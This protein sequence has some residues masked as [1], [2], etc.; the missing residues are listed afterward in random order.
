MKRLRE[1][2]DGFESVGNNNNNRELMSRKI[3]VKLIQNE[4]DNSLSSQGEMEW[5]EG[6]VRSLNPQPCID[7]HGYDKDMIGPVGVRFLKRVEPGLLADPWLAGK[8]G[9][10]CRIGKGNPKWTCEVCLC[11]FR[12]EEAGAS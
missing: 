7:G 8:Y 12:S 11:F 9:G 6:V 5:V 3:G 10:C 2:E 4:P 1:A